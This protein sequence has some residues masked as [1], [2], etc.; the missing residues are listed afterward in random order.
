MNRARRFSDKRSTFYK[1]TNDSGRQCD[2]IREMR[3]IWSP[4]RAY[5]LEPVLLNQ[6]VKKSN[7]GKR[8]FNHWFCRERKPMNSKKI[9]FDLS[10]GFT[11]CF[12]IGLHSAFIIV[13]FLTIIGCSQE[14]LLD[15]FT[16]KAEVEFS[17][18]YF[19]RLTHEIHG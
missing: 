14:E 12:F 11:D 17:K 13:L 3:W 9:S 7:P 8:P 18:K 4:P 16:P 5:Y 2:N 15:K 1:S 19:I 6:Y 10:F